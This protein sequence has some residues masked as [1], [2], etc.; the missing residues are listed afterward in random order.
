MVALGRLERDE[1]FNFAHSMKLAD[2]KGGGCTI[3]S[4]SNAAVLVLLYS[5]CIRAVRHLVIVSVEAKFDLPSL[6]A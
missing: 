1:Q 3:D 2:N 5:T 4:V 6:P